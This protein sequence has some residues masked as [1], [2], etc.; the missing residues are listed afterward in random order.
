MDPRIRIHT[1]MSWIRNSV[2][3]WHFRIIPLSTR[4]FFHWSIPLN[5]GLNV[6]CRASVPARESQLLQGH[7]HVLPH[8]HL[9]QDPRQATESFLA[10]FFHFQFCQ[11]SVCSVSGFKRIFWYRQ[12]KF[13]L[14]YGY[15][16]RRYCR[17]RMYVVQHRTGTDS[18]F[19]KHLLI[20]MYRM[21]S[22]IMYRYRY[23]V[24]FNKL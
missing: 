16:S 3:K 10:I 6:L 4:L 21:P 8:G 7:L 22:S 12:K 1:K 18:R 13:V 2:L 20:R 24:G 19:I 11:P 15:T 5:M 17:T 14:L 23:L 9:W